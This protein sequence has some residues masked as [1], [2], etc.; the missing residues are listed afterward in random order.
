LVDLIDGVVPRG[1]HDLVG[2]LH[3]D[4]VALGAQKVHREAPPGDRGLDLQGEGGVVLEA[5]VLHAVVHRGVHPVG[6][7]PDDIPVGIAL[8]DLQIGP[9]GGQVHRGGALAHPAAGLLDGLTP[10]VGGG[11][12]EAPGGG[13]AAHDAVV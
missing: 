13:A 4:V 8:H 12:E 3:G 9:E 10:H 6:D 5:E 1:A 2:H 11:G 7:V